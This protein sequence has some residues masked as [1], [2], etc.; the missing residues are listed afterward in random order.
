MKQIIVLTRAQLGSA[1]DFLKIF[2][3]TE[4]SKAKNMS[5]SLVL[6]L[7]FLLFAG[8][9]GVYTWLMAAA[10]S[11]AGE[12]QIL[13]GI[14]L[15]LVCVMNL[16]TTIY[17]IK[18]TLFGFKDYDV[19]MALPVKTGSVV[20][21]RL[22][23]LYILNF[24]FTLVVMLPCNI[25]YGIFAE[26]SISYYVLSFV[27]L[28]FIPLVP[29]V[30]A[31]II[32]T[33]IAAVTSKFRKSNFVNTIVIIV[34]VVAALVL[35]FSVI[36][37]PSQLMSIGIMMNEMIGKVYPIATLYMQGVI[38]LD[39]IS[40]AGFILISVAAFGL[41]SAVVGRFFVK[42]SSSIASVRTSSNYK[43]KEQL[44]SS[45]LRALYRK[46]LKRFLSCSVYLLNTSIGVILMTIAGVALIIL[47]PEQL[48]IMLEIPMISDILPYIGMLFLTFLSSTVTTSASSISLEGKN[49]WI[50][51]SVPVPARTIFNSK[52]LLNI[53]IMFPFLLVNVVIFS[54]VLKASILEA[55]LLFLVPFALNCFISVFGLWLNSKFAVFNWTS[56]VVVVKQS[57]SAM[58]TLFV[59]MGLLIL[60]VLCY[61]L[62]DL[63]L[64]LVA[65][66]FALVLFVAAAFIYLYLNKNAEYILTNLN[67]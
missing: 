38:E 54:I 5:A 59:G 51:K 45:P 21:S 1:V 28:F 58:I 12:L 33:L 65:V 31:G 56:E 64:M 53:S 41:F 13:P 44:V 17:K 23:L 63:P 35:Y 49:L 14:M 15:T 36:S 48:M 52:I 27:S 11:E 22:M 66:G 67:N 34:F 2:H 7:A 8:L 43:L 37:D 3:K 40:M 61:A 42:M 20:A 26:A 4:R 10:L 9:F 47:Q 55:L 50:I 24:F 18:G 32:G 57:A 29:I 25:I 30:I 62:L 46:E 16:F 60:P 6:L 19:I 39:L